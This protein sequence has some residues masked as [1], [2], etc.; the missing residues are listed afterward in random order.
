MFSHACLSSLG[1]GITLTSS[2]NDLGSCLRDKKYNNVM[3][4]FN[5]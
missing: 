5:T 2:C 3:I 4:L 1:N